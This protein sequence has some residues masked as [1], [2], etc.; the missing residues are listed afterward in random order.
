MYS[1]KPG[2]RLLVHSTGAVCPE[3]H[4]FSI[5]NTRNSEP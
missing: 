1:L 3:K 5:A 4:C 2:A